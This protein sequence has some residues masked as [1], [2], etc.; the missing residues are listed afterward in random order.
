MNAIVNQATSL[1]ATAIILAHNHPNGNLHPSPED[2]RSTQRLAS[3]AAA[4]GIQ[5]VDHF[6]LTHDGHRSM[7]TGDEGARCQTFGSVPGLVKPTQL[8]ATRCP[9]GV[10]IP[11]LMMS[12]KASS[13]VMLTFLSSCAGTRR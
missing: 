13:L 10:T 8:L 11:A 12:L 6:I 5:L 3:A 2:R 7:K 9:P 4:Q 1:G